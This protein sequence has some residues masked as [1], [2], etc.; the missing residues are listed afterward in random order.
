M[1]SNLCRSQALGLYY[2]ATL[3]KRRQNENRWLQDGQAPCTVLFYHRVADDHPNAWTIGVR[4]FKQQIEW[5]RERFKIVS[6][7][8]VQRVVASGSSQ[9]PLVAITF[10]DGYADNCDAALPWLIQ[11]GVPLTYFVTTGNTASGRPFPHDELAGVP[12]HPN[13]PDQIRELVAS[14]VELGCHTRT[15]ADLGSEMH[16]GAL[17]DEIVGS[18]QDL[19]DLIGQQVRYFAFPFGLPE[20]MTPAGFEIARQAGL[21]GVCSAYGA[22]NMPRSD[23]FHIRRIHGDPEW[24]R[25]RNWLTVDPRKLQRPDPFDPI[26]R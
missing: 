21:R 24:G 3:P 2:Y 25:F 13:T 17:R 9:E 11:E 6:L 7:Q 5:V 15:H 12:L 19:E 8:E 1:L 14:G 23:S 4:Q 20:N 16:P 18:K 22:Y 10:D 26:D